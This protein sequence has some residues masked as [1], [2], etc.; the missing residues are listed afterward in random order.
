MTQREHVLAKPN[1]YIGD[2]KKNI[3]EEW[4]FDIEKQKMIKKELNYS[5]GLL[6]IFDEIISNTQDV[7][8]R[9][10]KKVTSVIVEI[11]ENIISVYNNGVIIPIEKMDNSE[12]YII[13][14]MF[15]QMLSSSNY[16]TDCEETIGTYGIGAKATNILSKK[17]KVEVYDHENQLHFLQEWTDNMA[18]CSEPIII[19]GKY[20]ESYTKITFEPDLKIFNTKSFSEDILDIFRKRCI[21]LAAVCNEMSVS[22]NKEKYKFKNIQDYFSLY[23]SKD[24]IFE[25]GID[26][27]YYIVP[28]FQ[29][30]QLSFV[31]GNYTQRG[32]H[33]NDFISLI[34]KIIKDELERKK[35]KTNMRISNYLKSKI[36]LFLNC[37]IIGPKFSSQ[38]K[39]ELVDGI[40]PKFEISKKNIKKLINSPITQNLLKDIQ[41]KEMK[42]II[43]VVNKKIPLRTITKLDD[44]EMAGTRESSK[45]HLI[46]TEGDSAKT[47]AICGL[48]IIGR[49][50]Y[51]VFPLKGK[52]INARNSSPIKISKNQE[53]KNLITIL[54]LNINKK[55]ESVSSL[56]YGKIMLM[57]DQDHDGSHIKGL[58]INFFHFYWPELLEL[59][60]ISQFITPIVKVTKK[61][62]KISFYNTIEF[63]D[64]YETEKSGNWNIKYY[65]G[66]GTSNDK[67][68]E[69]YFKNKNSHVLD[70]VYD[71]KR[72]EKEIIKGFC[73]NE[74]EK[75]KIWLQDMDPNQVLYSNNSKKSHISYTDFINKEL[76]HFSNAD[77][78]RSISNVIDGFKPVQRKIMFT[79]FEMYNE[80]KNKEI[81]VEE[82]SGITSSKTS[83]HHGADSIKKTIIHMANDYVGSNNINLLSPNGQYGSR[84]A[85][86]K[87][88]ASPRYIFTTLQEITKKI[89][90]KEDENILEYNVEENKSIE[91]N[92]YIPIIPLIL[93]NGSRG[94]GTG[95]RTNIP[96][97][98][99]IEI[100]DHLLKIQIR[101]YFT[102]WYRNFTGMTFKINDSTFILSGIVNINDSEKSIKISELPIGTWTNTFKEKLAKDTNIE[103]K[104]MSSKDRVLFEIKFIEDSEYDK[105]KNQKN[106]FYNYF[107]I[108]TKIKT[109]N[110][111]AFDSQNKLKEYSG[112]IEIIN[113]FSSVRLLA[114]KKRKEYLLNFL[115]EKNQILNSRYRFIKQIIK[116]ELI[117][118][119]RK[120][121]DIEK[122]LIEL[123]YY[124]DKNNFN[125]LLKMSVDVFTIEKLE[126]LKKKI[127]ALEIVIETILKKSPEQM[128]EEELLELKKYIIENTKNFKRTKFEDFIR[129][130]F[131]NE[132]VDIEEIEELKVVDS[133]IEYSDEE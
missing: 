93:I 18:N 66:L 111:V 121:S 122:E 12:F 35:I 44:A 117:I 120:I 56:R 101:N 84:L 55:Y 15:G 61:D 102:P 125:Y 40:C 48:K 90:I 76:I 98:N 81:K 47:M 24:I 89:F 132:N 13:T 75:R 79:L 67:E 20:K 7:Y 39:E 133:D 11:N 2:S 85:G 29:S 109:K 31:N 57:T 131:V 43:S 129:L 19:K 32:K 17:F 130:P 25:N 74:A 70:F 21:D 37:K 1:M 26:F 99:P 116:K 4:K 127:E 59:G 71:K 113:E 49:K 58:I 92:F 33:I 51:G 72:D 69:E 28:D 104:E 65:K 8:I 34:A 3:F 63:N 9:H 27:D 30:D 87:D 128:W 126:E 50:Y 53:I 82:L 86:G 80:N 119:K 106:G 103:F 68:I 14:V 23:S 88:C 22:F 62:K 115:N 64:W 77:N 118:F 96:C 41:E 124:K 95:W 83:Y 78:I 94:L 60:F 16:Q 97:F 38:S 54:G 123:N 46:L 42:E 36:F 10:N 52:L 6:K 100:I 45:C 73:K 5:K 108:L 110:L 105:L 107:K 114:Y 91:P 112:P